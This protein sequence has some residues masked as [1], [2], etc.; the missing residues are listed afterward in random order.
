MCSLGRLKAAATATKQTANTSHALSRC[1]AHETTNGASKMEHVKQTQTHT[2][3]SAHGTT[4]PPI[5]RARGSATRPRTPFSPAERLMAYDHAQAT[6]D[7]TTQQRRCSWLNITTY[8]CR[9]NLTQW[10]L[11]VIYFG[12]GL[13]P[14]L[15]N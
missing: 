13:T 3:L 2:P 6:P 9:S 5:P 12:R 1:A 10:H 11:T 8:P 14:K 4:V 7:R 15:R